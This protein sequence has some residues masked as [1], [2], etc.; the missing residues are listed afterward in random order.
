MS[1]GSIIGVL[2]LL[3]ATGIAASQLISVSTAEDTSAPAVVACTGSAAI[4]FAC[5]ARRYRQLV[6]RDGARAALRALA[7]DQR[8][9]GYVR[10]A[11]HQ[12]THRIG[13]AAGALHGIDALR[14]GRSVCASGYY[15]GVLQAVMGRAGARASVERAAAIC[16]ASRADERRSAEHYNCVHGMGHGF[17]EVF[18]SRVFQSLHGCEALRD[19]WEQDE[20]SGGVFMENV[21]A[22]DNRARPARSLRSGQPLYP[23]TAV[24]RRFWEQC[25]DWQVTYALYVNDSDFG[26]VFGLCAATPV[27]ARRPCY[28]GL[29]GDALQQSN[30]VTSPAARRATI[31]R[32][33]AMGPGRAARRACIEGAVRNMYRDYADGDVQARALCASMRD[34]RAGAERA[35]CR[36]AEAKTRRAVALPETA[37]P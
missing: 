37:Q 26:A 18:S 19:R 15:H 13:R 17:M 16:A 29:G 25:Y 27:G 10:A 3:A 24:A 21:T 5:H 9:N 20:C 8:R 12:L 36:R 4:E 28:R 1:G 35:A 30:F 34:V 33:C 7:A 14:D 2:A 23:C 22:I 31:R 32:L 6:R 11:C